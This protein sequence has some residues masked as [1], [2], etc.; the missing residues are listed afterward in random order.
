MD[1]QINFNTSMLIENLTTAVKIA[2]GQRSEETLATL[3]SCHLAVSII[4][5][6]KK[7]YGD[8]QELIIPPAPSNKGG[9]SK[10]INRYLKLVTTFQEIY[11]DGPI[12]IIRAPARINIIGEHIDYIKY[13]QTC[14]LPFG[15]REYDMLMAMRKRD[16]DCIRAATTAEGLEPK[17]FRIREVNLEKVWNL[18]K[19]HT[20]RDDYWLQYLTSSIT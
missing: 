20:N 2:D 10:Q 15:S 13:F 3:P 4:E 14:V 6:I 18:F 8:A 11:G 5:S 12:T 16:D 17:E 9:V 19:V 7:I 1:S